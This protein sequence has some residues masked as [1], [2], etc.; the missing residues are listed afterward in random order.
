MGQG[1]KHDIMTLSE[2]GFGH[3]NNLCF[4][5]LFEMIVWTLR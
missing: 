1:S 3:D 5:R 2:R 4:R